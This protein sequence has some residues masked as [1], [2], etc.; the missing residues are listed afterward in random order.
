M[1][2]DRLLLFLGTKVPPMSDVLLIL[3]KANILHEEVM[4]FRSSY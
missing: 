4:N 2:S 1:C 3:R